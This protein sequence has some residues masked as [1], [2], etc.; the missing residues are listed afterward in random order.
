MQ[1]K[2]VNLKQMILSVEFDFFIISLKNTIC[3]II[4][5]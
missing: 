3:Q 1:I 5:L 4:Q 2:K